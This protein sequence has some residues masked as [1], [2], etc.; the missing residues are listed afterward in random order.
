MSGGLQERERLE[1]RAVTRTQDSIAGTR[2]VS[3]TAPAAACP[4][5]WLGWG[6]PLCVGTCLVP[7]KLSLS[8]APGAILPAPAGCAERGRAASMVLAS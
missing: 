8:V 3:P 6:T 2:P 5:G 4:Q 7:L 1:Q